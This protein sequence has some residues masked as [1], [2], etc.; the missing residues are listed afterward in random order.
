MKILFVSICFLI[1]C[2]SFSQSDTLLRK[3]DQQLLYRYG[4]GFMKGGNKVSFTELREEFTSLSISFDLYSKA[5]KDKTISTVL[6]YVSMLAIIGVAK[7]ASDNNRT[8]IYGF[9]AG[10]LVLIFVS[11]T[12]YQK[13][14][15]ETDKAIQLRNRELLFPGQQ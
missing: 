4:S 5:K 6:R 3:Y 11:Q 8:M 13:S 12:F 7:G 1:S 14:I 15:L 9:M 10:Q 2:H